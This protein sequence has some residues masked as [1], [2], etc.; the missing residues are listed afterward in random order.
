MIIINNT[1]VF[2]RKDSHFVVLANLFK[3]FKKFGLKSLPIKCQ[4]FRDHI[5]YMD[6]TFMRK[7]D[8]SSY[9]PMRE[10]CNVIFYLRALKSVKITDIILHYGYFLVIIS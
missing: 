2:S 6:L 7:Y 3:L 4:A 8:K 10:K 5:T 1:M 9:I